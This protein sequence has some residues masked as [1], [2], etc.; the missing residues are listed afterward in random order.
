MA[1][2][3]QPAD[4]ARAAVPSSSWSRSSAGKSARVRN[5]TSFA[6]LAP[7]RMLMM[8]SSSVASLNCAAACSSPSTWV[9]WRNMPR[10][11]SDLAAM[12]MAT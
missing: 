3:P 6:A 2:S 11:S 5:C 10:C 9:S 8:V 7:V 4:L 1:A 12:P